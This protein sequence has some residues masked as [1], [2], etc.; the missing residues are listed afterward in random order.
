MKTDNLSLSSPRLLISLFTLTIASQHSLAQGLEEIVVTAQKREQAVTDIPVTINTF[1]GEQLDNIGIVDT[2]DLDKLVPGLTVGESGF[3][4]PIYTMRGVG[5]NER[6]LTAQPTVSVYTDEFNFPYALTTKGPLLDVA[7]IEVLKG[8]QGILYGR[9]TTGGAINYVT[10]KPTTEFDAGARLSY[11]RYETIDAE[12]FVSGPFSDTVSGRA[13]VR[14]I[15]SDKGDQK[16]ITRPGDRLGKKDVLAYRGQLQFTPTETFLLRASVDGWK[17]QSD[18]RAP[19]AIAIVPQVP[20]NLPFT[21]HGSYPVVGI[22]EDN[23]R[24]ADWGAPGSGIPT[25]IDWKNDDSQV[26]AGLR[27]EWDI[28]NK[29]KLTALGSYLEL[30]VDEATP[31]SGLSYQHNDQ[32]VVAELKTRAFEIRLS[33]A[34][35]VQDQFEW[36]IGSNYSKDKSHSLRTQ[37]LGA[38]TSLVDTIT[39][40]FNQFSDRNP[41]R[42]N[43]SIEQWG[44]FAN[45]SWR[46]LPDFTLHLGARYNEQKQDFYA[47]PYEASGTTA[48]TLTNGISLSTLLGAAKDQCFALDDNL[49]PGAFT[50]SLDEDNFS[51]RI[52]L[53][54]HATDDTLLYISYARGYK[55]GGFPAPA[56]SRQL[57]YNPVTQEK[58]LALEVGAKAFLA[59]RQVQVNV[60]VYDYDY[61]DKQLFTKVLDPLFGPLGIIDNAPKSKVRGVDLDMRYA[62]AWAP[63]LV[64]A[65]TGAYVDTEVKEFFGLDNQGAPTDFSGRPFN[66]APKWQYTLM[67]DYERP[68]SES[69]V[70]FISADY[71]YADDTNASLEGDPLYALDSYGLLGARIGVKSSSGRWSAMLWGRNLT[72]DFKATGILSNGDVLARW[73]TEG[74]TYGI[75]LEYDFK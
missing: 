59:N 56:A 3:G 42:D 46:F 30:D 58:V 17:D 14:I 55:A 32:E 27:A 45:T 4:I 65:A 71:N 53:D 39:G 54:W 61:D 8:P 20:A 52:A 6:T 9:N 21:P 28:T 74:R 49:Q 31:S 19:Q 72:D 22:D 50:G 35:G 43:V 69:L 7:R 26:L 25:D 57:Q 68:V 37:R 33:G 51:Y 1:T 34:A 24:K 36:M 13:A 44:V 62:P 75:A 2:R 47:C 15:N 38:N 40:T 60:A 12:G 11:G 41:L 67:F 5:F 64:L 10:N 66:F 63:G 16:S 23:P 70:G 29:V 18:P 73:N 48:G